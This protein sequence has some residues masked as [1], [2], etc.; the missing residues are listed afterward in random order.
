MLRCAYFSEELEQ[1]MTDG[2]TTETMED[3][4]S[5]VCSASHLTAFSVIAYDSQPVSL[6]ESVHWCVSVYVCVCV[7]V[8]VCVHVC[9]HVC[10][11]VCVCMCVCMCV[12]ACMRAC[13]C[14]CVCM[15]VFVCMCVCVYASVCIPTIHMRILHFTLLYVCCVSCHTGVSSTSSLENCNAYRMLCGGCASATGLCLQLL[16][17]VS[18]VHYPALIA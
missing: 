3:G 8:C 9:V 16:P 4:R 15:C 11:C 12:C 14:A 6:T 13:V 1:W 10:V 5:V 7:C 18:T 2:V 17:L